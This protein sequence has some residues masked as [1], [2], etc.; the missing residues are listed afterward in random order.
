MHASLEAAL[1]KNAVLLRAAAEGGVATGPAEDTDAEEGGAA[2]GSVATSPEAGGAA[3]GLDG[4]A[5]AEAGGAA[6]DGG[7]AAE[8]P[9]GTASDGAAARDVPDGG[10]GTASN[11]SC[12][13]VAGHE[14]TSGRA[15]DQLQAGHAEA[16]SEGAVEAA[17]PR[18]VQPQAGHLE[19][20]SEG[21]SEATAPFAVQPQAGPSEAASEGAAEAATQRAVQPPPVDLNV[22]GLVDES[23]QPFPISPQ[24]TAPPQMPAGSV[25]D[26]P[27]Q[28][29]P[30][31]MP[32]GNVLDSPVS[33]SGL[34]DDQTAALVALAQSGDLPRAR[35]SAAQAVHLGGLTWGQTRQLQGLSTQ[36]M[37]QY[38]GLQRMLWRPE[39]AE[40]P[41]VDM[42]DAVLPS[43]RSG[44]CSSRS[45]ES[46][47]SSDAGAVRAAIELPRPSGRARLEATRRQLL[48]S[49][50]SGEES[51]VGD[52][53]R[54]ESSEHGV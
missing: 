49:D 21:G 26:S 15:A 10:T 9:A 31:Q 51:D 44:Y 4:G 24:Q 39:T 38:A 32:A 20:V 6:T 45:G 18:G 5:G 28:P 34:S 17:M 37:G 42:Q 43:E 14:T 46:V 30:P 47:R 54:E 12:V 22:A 36:G 35:L 41:A 1:A 40:A 13:G 16:A 48:G 7:A 33:G 3:T 27:E 29:A 2:E 25:L 11:S 52:G 8:R 53:S 23:P 50:S 19:A